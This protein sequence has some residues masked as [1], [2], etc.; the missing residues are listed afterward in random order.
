ML[1]VVIL[2]FFERLQDPQATQAM[3][4]NTHSRLALPLH[5][6]Q[7]ACNPLLLS[8]FRSR[9]LA[10]EKERL[11]FYTVLQLLALRRL[12]AVAFQTA[13]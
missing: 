2:Q 7:C 4:Y 13:G 1:A 9:T 5:E 12:G 10:G 8:I 6:S 11:V 3:Q